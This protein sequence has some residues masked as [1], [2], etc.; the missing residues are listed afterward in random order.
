MPHGRPAGPAPHLQ[1]RPPPPLPPGQAF[2]VDFGDFRWF[3]LDELKG[4]RFVGGFGRVGT[5]KAEDYAAARPDPVAAFA[6]P[7]CGH[8]NAD[9]EGD[10][11]AM[12]K[13]YVGLTAAKAR[14]LDL[15]RLG[16]NLQ[17]TQE[18]GGASFKVRLPFVRW[19]GGGSGVLRAAV[20]TLGPRP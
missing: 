9:H 18:E 19:G 12:L 16:T 5:I 7:V 13:H 3:R 14:M 20:M 11:L 6:G 15:D 8:M 2:Y 17:V 10:I 1:A 4:G